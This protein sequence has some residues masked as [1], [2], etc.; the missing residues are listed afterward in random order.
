MYFSPVL[1]H[2][3]IHRFQDCLLTGGYLAVG[4]SEGVLI[5]EPGL[6]TVCL[7]QS[8]LYKKVKADAFKGKQTKLNENS[9]PTINN[10]TEKYSTKKKLERS[11]NRK[12]IE[13]KSKAVTLNIGSKT[14]LE[15]KSG[16]GYEQALKLYSEEKYIEALERL[17]EADIKTKDELKVKKLLVRLYA[18]LGNHSEAART[19]KEGLELDM[20]D[21]ECYYLQ[22][23][24]SL[25]M[26]EEK[27]AERLFFRAIYLNPDYELAH[28]AMANSSLHSGHI[29]KAKKYFKNAADL[30]RSYPADE[31]IP[32]SDNLTASRLLQ[33]ISSIVNNIVRYEKVS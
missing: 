12:N 9:V 31:I 18:N 10:A 22:G 16:A 6:T 3:I 29:V 17:K 1:V 28:Y 25:E 23:L 13:K 4:G 14:L 8:I 26:G 15:S 2:K 27:D 30:L 21:P 19:C 5:N 20:F 7:P 11:I 24:L 33:I 32:G